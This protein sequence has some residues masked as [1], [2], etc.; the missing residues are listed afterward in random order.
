MRRYLNALYIVYLS[1]KR[2]RYRKS[3]IKDRLAVSFER[4][5]LTQRGAKR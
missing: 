5:R 4:L 3:G 2:G 1:A